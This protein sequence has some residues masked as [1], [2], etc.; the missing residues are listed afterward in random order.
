MSDRQ[1]R[2]FGALLE[3]CHDGI[4]ISD[5]QDGW[6]MECSRSF[7]TLTGYARHELLG[8]TSLELG[9]IDPQ[10]RE[11]ALADTN[12]RRAASGFRTPLRRKDGERVWVEFSPQVLAGDE[13]MLTIVRRVET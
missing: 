9:L 6:M 13:L 11:T 7:E 2:D 1:R 3:S 8:R 5:C 10:I 12:E 4:V